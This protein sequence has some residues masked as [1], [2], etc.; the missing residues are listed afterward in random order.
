MDFLGMGMGE[1]VLILVIALVLLGPGKVL[2][3]ARTLGR[4]MRNLKKITS[5]LTTQIALE[6]KEKE[7]SDTAQKA[8]PLAKQPHK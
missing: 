4:M 6:A 2:D 5:D 3:V 1:I 8:Q 7:A